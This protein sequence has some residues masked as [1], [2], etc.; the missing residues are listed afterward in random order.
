MKFTSVDSTPYDGDIAFFRV[1]LVSIS[2]SNMAEKL[3]ERLAQITALEAR[4]LLAIGD[5]PGST[6]TEISLQTSL[7]PVQVGR[8][9]SRLKAIKLIVAHPCL[10]DGRAYKLLLTTEGKQRHAIAHHVSVVVQHWAIRRLQPAAWHEFSRTLDVLVESSRFSEEDV[11][12]LEV[13]LLQ[14]ADGSDQWR[15]G[16]GSTPK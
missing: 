16:D 9:I 13:L 6:A 8:C 1:R 15:Q 7:T 2:V 3:M 12:K 14:Q 10:L 11:A 4:V 5:A